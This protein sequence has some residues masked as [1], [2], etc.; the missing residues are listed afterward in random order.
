MSGTKLIRWSGCMAALGGIFMA[1]SMLIHPWAQRTGDIATT[2]QWFVSH[3]SH[4]V[5]AVLMV[6]GLFGLYLRQRE[7]TGKPGLFSFLVAYLGTVLFVA[8]GVTSTFWWPAIAQDAP[9]FVVDGGPLFKNWLTKGSMLAAR[10]FLVLGY[11]WFGFVSF[12]AGILP[13]VGSLLVIVGAVAMNLPTPPVGPVPWVVTVIGA[14]V[15]CL[16]L[17]SWGRA[18]WTEAPEAHEAPIAFLKTK[19]LVVGF[20]VVAILIGVAASIS[21]GNT[22]RNC[23]TL[24]GSD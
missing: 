23:L 11:G 18:L 14:V 10:V 5:G 7:A 24:V 4:L 3:A 17:L 9:S 22:I 2:L 15:F 21:Y 8:T 19:K 16:G 20:A 6:L 1:A 13:R 12:R